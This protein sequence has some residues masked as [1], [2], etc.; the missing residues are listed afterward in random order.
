MEEETKEKKGSWSA[1]LS[2]S[3]VHFF[4]DKVLKTLWKI[5]KRYL[6]VVVSLALTAIL[7]ASAI[8]LLS[9]SVAVCNKTE[10]R[11]V[12]AEFLS[13]TGMQF[14]CILVLGCRV[15]EDGRMSDMLSDRVSVGVS[16]YKNG[17]SNT[18]LMSG[19]SEHA[20]EYDEVGAMKRAVIDAGI[21]SDAVLTDPYGLSTYDSLI[22]LRDIYG[23]ERVLIVTQEYHLYR[24]LYIAEKLGMEAFGVSADLQPYRNQ[25]MR[26]L[27]E[28]PARCKDVYYALAQP[29]P[30]YE[31]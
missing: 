16:L 1:A 12:T 26:D 17:L 8:F 20:E 6:L 29:K 3:V 30:K 4:R 27:R 7:L 15:W 31:A 22:R 9:V 25:F 21:A 28:I 23:A 2:K 24:A 10:D 18:I 14:D 13:E 5:R 11:I 19:D